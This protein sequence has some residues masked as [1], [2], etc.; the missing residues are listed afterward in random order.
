MRVN[1]SDCCGMNYTYQHPGTHAGVGCGS[2]WGSSQFGFSVLRFYDIT[3]IV[4][5]SSQYI[6]SHCQ[7]KPEYYCRNCN[8]RSYSMIFLVRAYFNKKWWLNQHQTQGYRH[9]QSAL[10][11]LVWLI[12]HRAMWMHLVAHAL[13]LNSHHYQSRTWLSIKIRKKRTYI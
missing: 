4:H 12:F 11:I 7:V 6:L 3:I 1:G 5:I 9:R 13:I 8:T 2:S 10:E